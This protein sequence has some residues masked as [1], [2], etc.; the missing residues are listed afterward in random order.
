MVLTTC[1]M[2]LSMFRLLEETLISEMQSERRGWA[3]SVKVKHCK[4]G[5]PYSV[6]Y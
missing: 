5:L 3:M 4:T 6:I 1:S 2:L